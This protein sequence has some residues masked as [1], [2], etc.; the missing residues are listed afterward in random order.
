MNKH[1]GNFGDVVKHLLLAELLERECG[2][3]TTYIDP[4]AGRPM[5]DLSQREYS[6]A[7]RSTRTIAAG[8]P[9]ADR[10]M[11]LASGGAFQGARYT[12]ILKGVGFPQVLCYPGSAQIASSV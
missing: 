9:W 10:Y 5:N 8:L 12:R 3:I 7:R 4:Y 1:A 11:R 2:R 6:Y